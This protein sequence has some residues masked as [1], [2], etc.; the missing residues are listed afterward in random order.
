MPKWASHRRLLGP[1]G[2]VLPLDLR[3]FPLHGLHLIRTASRLKN[4]LPPQEGAWKQR[5]KCQRQMTAPTAVASATALERP[6]ARFEWR[7]QLSVNVQSTRNIF[8]LVLLLL[9]MRLLVVFPRVEPFSVRELLFFT[10]AKWKLGYEKSCY[11]YTRIFVLRFVLAQMPQMHSAPFLPPC[12][13]LFI[14]Q[15]STLCQSQKSG[16]AN[17][18]REQK[19]NTKTTKAH[20]YQVWR[21]RMM[22]CLGIPCKLKEN[23]L[24]KYLRCS[25][26]KVEGLFQA[27]NSN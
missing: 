4:T 14:Y 18:R 26:W 10:H 23:C 17:K 11:V 12:L 9:L 15:I 24:F 20:T 3:L 27:R 25:I 19:Q 21:H 13:T 6:P 7:Q 1:P 2:H 8:G 16:A 5:N 22:Y